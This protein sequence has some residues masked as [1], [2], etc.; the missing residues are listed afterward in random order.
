MPII[1]LIATIGFVLFLLL[2]Q[3]FRK[4]SDEDK[5]NFRRLSLWTI[6]VSGLI[7]LILTGRFF[8]ALGWAFMVLI[9]LLVAGTLSRKR[10]RSLPLLTDQ[11]RPLSEKK[12]H[13]I[14]GLSKGASQKEIQNAYI[15]LIKIHHPDNGGSEDMSALLNEAFDLLMDPDR[16]RD[17]NDESEDL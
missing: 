4:A 3:W 11:S 12:A 6:A 15:R 17:Q 7:I 8:H 14:L 5:K 1:I 16:W 2:R 13:E 10:S 9:V